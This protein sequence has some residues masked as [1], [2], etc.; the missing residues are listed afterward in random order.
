M[1]GLLIYSR[2]IPTWA[3]FSSFK[4]QALKVREAVQAMMEVP[5]QKVKDDMVC[6]LIYT[7]NRSHLTSL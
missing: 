6:P 5:F 3:P 2:H 1:V 7:L 4:V